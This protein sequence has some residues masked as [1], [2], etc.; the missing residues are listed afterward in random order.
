MEN[1]DLEPLESDQTDRSPLYPEWFGDGKPNEAFCPSQQRNP[2]FP[3]PLFLPMLQKQKLVLEWWTKWLFWAAIGDK[4]RETHH[5]WSS[6]RAENPCQLRNAGVKGLF[7]NWTRGSLGWEGEMQVWKEKDCWNVCGV[8]W[9][10]WGLS[11]GT[12]EIKKEMMVH[13][14]AILNS[15]VYFVNLL[16]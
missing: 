13:A 7:G 10:F 11:F 6:K 9:W 12:K 2:C 16:V 5:C 8:F 15:Y 4:L 1:L 14:N 3:P